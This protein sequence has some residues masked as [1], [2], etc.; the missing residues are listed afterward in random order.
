MQ[1]NIDTRGRAARRSGG[2]ICCLLGAASLG[3]GFWGWYRA[4]SLGA[5][6]I[7]ILAGLFQLFEA[8]RGWC[9]LRAMGFKTPV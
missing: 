8:S 1:C 4:A 2:I 7:L 6:V 9:A 3:L 5:G